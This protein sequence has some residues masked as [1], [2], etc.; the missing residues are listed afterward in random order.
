MFN[1][2][3]G[4]YKVDNGI[5]EVDRYYV[6]SLKNPRKPVLLRFSCRDKLL[7]MMYIMSKPHPEL[8]EV[9]SGEEALYR[10]I[11]ISN[12]GLK[13]N[14]LPEKYHYPPGCNTWQKKKQHRTNYRDDIRRAFESINT[15]KQFTISYKS[16]SY[17]IFELTISNAFKYLNQYTG[18]KWKHFIS[19]VDNKPQKLPKGTILIKSYRVNM[20]M[21][22]TYMKGKGIN[23]FKTNPTHGRVTKLESGSIVANK[24][25]PKQLLY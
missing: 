2:A 10:G 22:D 8:F 23:I 21:V 14:L 9:I 11:K 1:H 5:I 18:M 24:K 16:R 13:K 17:C 12:R 7:A 19:H 3:R 20:V 15:I 4:Y 6:L 25:K